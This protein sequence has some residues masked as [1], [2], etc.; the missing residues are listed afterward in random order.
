[1]AASGSRTKVRCSISR[2][3]I[4]RPRDRTVP[5]L[6]R[7]ISRSSTRGPQ[8]LPGRRP[9]SRSSRLSSS[10]IC[11]RLKCA[12][13]QRDCIGEVAAGAAV[14]GV[15]DDRRRIEQ[16]E[17]AG[18]ARRS[19]LRPRPRADHAAHAA[20]WSRSRS[21]RGALRLP[22]GSPR[23]GPCASPPPPSCRPSRKPKRRATVRCARALSRFAKSAGWSIPTWWNAPVPAFGDRGCLAGDRRPRTGK[24]RRQSNRTAFHRGFRR[25]ASLRDLVQVWA[26]RGR[27]YAL[28][29][30]TDCS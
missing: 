24:A 29:R 15:E 10:S 19:R 16:A 23:S 14:R 27:I 8:R 21:R 4:L 26:R 9:N 2:C 7:T 17:I 28:I 22:R 11:G 6:H 5:P 30:R 18:R 3:G 1:M 13:H 25:R 12:F 20:G